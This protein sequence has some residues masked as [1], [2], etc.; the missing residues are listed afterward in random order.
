M[1][2]AGE[3]EFA[4]ARPDPFEM[5]FEQGDAGI[6][7]EGHGFDQVEIRSGHLVRHLP[8]ETPFDQT[9]A[10]FGQGLRIRHNRRSHAQHRTAL[11]IF[12]FGQPQGADCH[13]ERRVSSAIRTR[14]IDPADRT[15]I[16]PARTRLDLGDPFHRPDFRRAGDRAAGEQCAD[17]IHRAFAGQQPRPHGRNHLV[18]RR[19]S[20]DGK[21][22]L[23]PHAAGLRHPRQIVAHQIDDHQIF[24][25][26]LDRGG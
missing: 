21:S 26:L 23:H 15:A 14:T 18:Q 4:R 11:A 2:V 1:A 9:L 6:G 13:I 8:H 25:A 10:P 7:A 24:G 3:A 5:E 17:H 22:I 16:R 19:I 20:L 12:A